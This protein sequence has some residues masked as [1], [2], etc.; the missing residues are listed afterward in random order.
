[1]SNDKI[2]KT[3]YLENMRLV[4]QWDFTVLILGSSLITLNSFVN[5][6]IRFKKPRS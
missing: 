6:R 4:V 5:E 3:V 2:S 1:M